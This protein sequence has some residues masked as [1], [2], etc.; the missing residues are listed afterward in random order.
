M[1]VCVCCVLG[2]ICKSL[3]R[4]EVCGWGLRLGRISGPFSFLQMSNRHTLSAQQRCEHSCTV[5]SEFTLNS[6]FVHMHHWLL[7]FSISLFFMKTCA[8]ALQMIHNVL[9]VRML[10]PSSDGLSHAILD[11][12]IYIYCLLWKNIEKSNLL[13]R[14]SIMDKCVC[15]CVWFAQGCLLLNVRQ[16][17]T[18]MRDLLCK[19]CPP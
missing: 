3:Q 10:Q 17:C 13:W 14:L 19:G 5:R 1:C 4:K 18:K 12:N 6:V 7:H 9:T 8:C 16:F 2:A 11:H 15:V